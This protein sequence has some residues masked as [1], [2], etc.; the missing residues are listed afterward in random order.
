M[1]TEGD[2]EK[3]SPLVVAVSIPETPAAPPSGRA[4]EAAVMGRSEPPKVLVSW[5]RMRDAP[6]EAWKV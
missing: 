1:V 2:P 3:V 6:I 5:K 4:T